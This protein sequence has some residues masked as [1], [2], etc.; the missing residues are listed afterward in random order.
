MATNPEPSTSFRP[1]RE[2]GEKRDSHPPLLADRNKKLQERPKK[3][4]NKYA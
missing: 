2:K 3:N 1:E 4:L